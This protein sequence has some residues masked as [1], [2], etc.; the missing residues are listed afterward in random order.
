[1]KD[2]GE[3]CPW[4]LVVHLHREHEWYTCVSGQVYVWDSG[5]VF[6]WSQCSWALRLRWC[7]DCLNSTWI[8]DRKFLLTWQE[9]GWRIIMVAPLRLTWRAVT[10]HIVI[11]HVKDY[12]LRCLLM[13]RISWRLMHMLTSDLQVGLQFDPAPW[14]CPN[15]LTLVGFLE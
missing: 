5:Q 8:P 2:N 7:C 12:Y 15:L 9:N 6:T 1:M 10:A 3:D 13:C 11:K 14:T 4:Q